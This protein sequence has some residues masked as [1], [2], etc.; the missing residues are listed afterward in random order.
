M[1]SQD[2]AFAGLARQ[3]ELVRDG[4]I[5]PVE[6]VELHL[7]RIERLEP[8][9]NAFR[10]VFAE[11]ALADARQAEGRRGAGGERPLLGVP[12]AVKD[13]IDVA[14]EVS[15]MGTHA[16]GAPAQ[17]DSEIVRRLRAAG[18]IIVGKTHLSELAIFPW[19]ETA[20]WGMTR[21][22]WAIDER[23]AGGSSGGSGSAVAAALVPGASASDGGGSI[24]VPASV[25]GLFG[26]KPQRGRVS[27]M[28][29]AQHWHGLS[30][31]GSVTRSVLDTALW[32]DVVS[33]P[34][35]G[36]A[37]SAPA[38]E[39]SFVEAA[40]TP[41]GKLRIA[42]S[43]KPATR[44]RVHSLVRRALDDT[45]ATLRSLGH[46]VG[47]ADPE[48]GL[49]EPL[50]FPRWAAG[51]YDD[52]QALPHPERVER[53]TKHV[54]RVGRILRGGPLKRALAGE[55]ARA[56][57]INKIF[58]DFDLLLTPTLPRPP[59]PL[60]RYENRTIAT[61]IAGASEIVAFT[62]VWNMTGQP[63]ASL[64]AA[65][66]DDG[67]PIGMQ[68]ISRPNDEATILSVAAQLEAEI[69]W[70]ERRPPLD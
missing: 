62:S 14:G 10:V 67:V 32:L 17:A 35:A 58:D 20:T 1:D 28:P 70:P 9:L 45:A 44:A 63:A 43:A 51:V 3:A 7:R 12:V 26:L 54:A 19:T 53:R 61:N 33:G 23:S 15:A 65:V 56:A 48:Y 4:E 13:N 31:A 2:L 41:P 50:F 11:R 8:R 38:P 47:E 57:Q 30:Q 39:R 27:L 42:V 21:N 55:A 37:H 40:S 46:D 16:G 6:L 34:A 60:G 29:D 18:A 22:P 25:N 69:A 59:W 52:V 66:T 36:D 5:S 24:R 49:L 64:P 68:L